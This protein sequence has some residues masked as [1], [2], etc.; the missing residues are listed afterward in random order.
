MSFLELCGI[1]GLGIAALVFVTACAFVFVEYS[2]QKRAAN[3]QQASE[4]IRYRRS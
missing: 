4:P 3:K 1:A 2:L